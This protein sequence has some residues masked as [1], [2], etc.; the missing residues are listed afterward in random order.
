MIIQFYNAAAGCKVHSAAV[1]AYASAGE[2][3]RFNPHL[4]A[5][6]L[7]GGFDPTGRFVHIPQLALARLS[8]YF[9]AWM[10]GFFLKHQLINERLARNM[11]QW[12]HSGF[13]LDGSVGIPAGSSRTR[14][15]LSQYIARAP[16]SLSKLVVEDH[17]ATVLYHTH[18][19]PLLPH[20]PQALPRRGLHRR[21]AAAPA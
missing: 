18:L 7:E 19:Q 6:V 11:L 1:I 10:V 2:F 5:I 8:Q 9:R 13:S 12:D 15:A 21:A 16:V 3:V 14:E 20:Q 4:H 17:A